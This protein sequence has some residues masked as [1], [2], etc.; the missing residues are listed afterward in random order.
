MSPNVFRCPAC[1]NQIQSGPGMSPGQLVQCPVCQH[2]FPLPSSTGATEP[3]P[4]PSPP[5]SF[6]PDYRPAA[7]YEAAP[8]PRLFSSNYTIN[9]GEWFRYAQAHY[10]A[11]LGMM[12]AYLLILF[13]VTFV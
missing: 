3:I 4:P 7:G 8:G 12:I 11:V 5:P 6:E 13:G 1:D 10:T 2:R 9:L